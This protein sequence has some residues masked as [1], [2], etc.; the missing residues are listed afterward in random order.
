MKDLGY[1]EGYEMYTRDELLPEKLKG[2]IYF[3]ENER[4]PK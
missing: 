2:K 1:G 3:D 4:A